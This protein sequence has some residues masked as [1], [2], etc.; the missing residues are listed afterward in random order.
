MSH[1]DHDKL[2]TLCHPAVNLVIVSY[3]TDSQTTFENVRKRWLP[4]VNQYAPQIPVVLVGLKKD[5]KDNMSTGTDTNEE[6]LVSE[7][8]G[9]KMK[10]E[11]G[12]EKYVH[13]LTKACKLYV[14]YYKPVYCEFP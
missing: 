11:I 5:L 3:S 8:Q 10:S 12:A 6:A 2:R 7:A 4:E 13:I 9:H 14:V 1:E